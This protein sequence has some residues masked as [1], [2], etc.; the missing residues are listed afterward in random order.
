MNQVRD[1]TSNWSSLTKETDATRVSQ[2]NTARVHVKQNNTRDFSSY[3]GQWSNFKV[4]LGTA[5]TWFV[6]DIAWY[7]LS[8]NSSVVLTLINFNGPTKTTFCRAIG[9]RCASPIQPFTPPVSVWEYFYQRAVGNIIIVA[10]GS[11]PGYWVTVALIEKMGRKPIQIMGFAVITLILIVLASKYDSLS[12]NAAVFM[13]L[14][15]IAQFFFNFGPNATTFVFPGEV[16]PTRWRST[17]HGISAACGKVGAILGIQAVGPYFTTN[18]TAV[19]WVFAV[20]M[21]TGIPM[22]FLIPET[23]GKTLEELSNED[24]VI[25]DEVLAH[26][27]GASTETIT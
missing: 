5:Y 22:T 17:G 4:L 26:Y 13:T 2:A 23:K 15:T 27:A 10:A 1:F 11:A 19:L 18:A 6:L 9:S 12:K 20:V 3:F 25:V 16:F 14:Y 7:G 24:N 21:A 8:L